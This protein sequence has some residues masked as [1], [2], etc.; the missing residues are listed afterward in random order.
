MRGHQV[1]FHSVMNMIPICKI[2]IWNVFRKLAF[3]SRSNLL[4]SFIYITLN[5]LET[6]NSVLVKI[7]LCNISTLRPSSVN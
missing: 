7:F 3:K 2:V 1:L 6:L 5:S 4:L